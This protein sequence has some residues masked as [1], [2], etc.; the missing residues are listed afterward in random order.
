LPR[1]ILTGT[2]GA[3][4]TAILRQ[5][6]Q[7]GYAVVEEAAT[8]VIALQQALGIP[9]PWRA[10]GFIDRIVDLQ[11]HRQIAADVLARGAAADALAHGVVV[12]D[13]SPVCTLALS[14]HLG[15][16]PS[17]AL[18]DEID[19]LRTERLYARTVFFVRNLGF[20]EATAAR[21]IS[22]DEALAFERLHELAYLQ[23]GFDLVEV[24]AGPLAAR[25]AL[26]G[27]TLAQ[28]LP[29]DASPVASRSAARVRGQDFSA[30]ASIT[31]PS[32][33]SRW[34]S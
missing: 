14:R 25:V 4:K 19:R 12:F 22:F 16:A 10:P 13:R 20:V 3:G 6:E 34:S 30:W 32:S 23:L 11:H 27:E 24:P 15:L 21:R 31:S 29:G 8:D 1:Y 17:P 26:V 7:D 28:R 9:E 33:W 5:L 2:P 18:R